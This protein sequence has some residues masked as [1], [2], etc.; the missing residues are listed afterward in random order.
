MPAPEGY[1]TPSIPTV[2]NLA[3][4]LAWFTT[5]DGVPVQP[6]GYAEMA[7]DNPEK[8]AYDASVATNTTQKAEIQAL[9]DAGE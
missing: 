3:D 5:G 6:A 4:R 2:D 7:A 8:V 1:D 9:I